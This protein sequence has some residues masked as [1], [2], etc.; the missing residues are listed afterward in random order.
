MRKSYKYN[1]E[2]VTMKATAISK[3]DALKKIKLFY[4]EASSKDVKQ[5]SRS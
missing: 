5:V 4:P 2:G 3:E 1:F